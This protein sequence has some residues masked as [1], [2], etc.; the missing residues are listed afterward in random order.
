MAFATVFAIGAS[1]W[2]LFFFEHGFEPSF[3][4][5]KRSVPA[6][7]TTAPAYTISAGVN[8]GATHR[9]AHLF[10]HRRAKS[11]TKEKTRED[12]GKLS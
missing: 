7:A 3:L 11:V 5:V 12:T 10:F 1:E 4:H 8:S 2:S 9:T 6:S